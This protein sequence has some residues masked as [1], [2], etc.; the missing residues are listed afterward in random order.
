MKFG[1]IT[2]NRQ[3]VT[4]TYLAITIGPIYETFRNVRHTRE[5]WGA[6]YLFSLIARRIIETLCHGNTTANAHHFIQPN[7]SDPTLF[8]TKT[9]VGLFPD[10]IIV[11]KA[12]LSDRDFE[13]I[14]EDIITELAA[15]IGDSKGFLKD[16]L[17][18]D[19]DL[20]DVQENEN[21]IKT[22]SAFLDAAELQPRFASQ[23]EQNPLKS[24]FKEIN[25]KEGFLSEHID[26]ENVQ[27]VNGNLRFES[28]AEIATR[29]L[30]KKDEKAKAAYRTLVNKYLWKNK[31]DHDKNTDKKDSDSD[32]IEVLQEGFKDDFKTYHKYICVVKADGDGIGGLLTGFIGDDKVTQI[33]KISKGLLDWGLKVKDTIR[34]YGGVPIYVGGDDL[35]FFAPVCNKHSQVEQATNI[36]QLLAN[37][38]ADFETAIPASGD[39]K[40]SLSFGLSISY[41][42]SPLSEAIAKAE[43]LLYQVKDKTNKA[44]GSKGGKL[45]VSLIKHSGSV[46][47]VELKLEKDNPLKMA[48]ERIYACMKEIDDKPFLNGVNYK[49]RENQG[50]IERV[51][52]DENRLENVF[53]NI[54]EE[55]LVE[56]KSKDKYLADLRAL[57]G[58]SFKNGY[59]QQKTDTQNHIKQGTAL[60]TTE[61]FSVVRLAK[62]LHGL[63]DLKD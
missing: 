46:F 21:P 33:Q 49:I 45:A 11:D 53:V 20:Y 2:T 44:Q 37:I 16:Y 60:A 12:I 27:D 3:S 13:A 42:K 54:F 24:F 18:I 29:E 47:D 19:W 62:F 61:V 58:L 7:I 17:R 48:Y 34:D 35:L 9:G 26:K 30:W 50:L 55:N 57:V 32:F 1:V 31:K 36:V 43:S 56:P 52:L 40:P 41:Y 39:T 10:R 15:L 51:A 25:E 63:D 28:L 5:V 59:Y 38:K 4:K 22:V 23:Y 6:S 14:K 8:D